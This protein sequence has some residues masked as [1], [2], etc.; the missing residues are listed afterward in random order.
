[1]GKVYEDSGVEM[2]YF[3]NDKL[4]GTEAKK[5]SFGTKEETS[6]AMARKFLKC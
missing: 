4:W 3:L 5:A 6:D 2:G 1:M